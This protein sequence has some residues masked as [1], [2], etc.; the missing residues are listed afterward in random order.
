MRTSAS[1]HTIS[2]GSLPCRFRNK[3]FLRPQRQSPNAKT[4]SSAAMKQSPQIQ[5]RARLPRRPNTLD[6]ELRRTPQRDERDRERERPTPKH[7]KR[8][9]RDIRP[10]RLKTT[11][12]YQPR[13]DAGATVPPLR[14]MRTHDPLSRL[15]QPTNGINTNSPSLGKR[16]RQ[17]TQTDDR[18]TKQQAIDAHLKSTINRIEDL[19]MLSTWQVN[20]L[21]RRRTSPAD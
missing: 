12:E 21:I 16:R 6:A 18:L 15:S 14:R 19:R 4:E 17:N 7:P 5:S 1:Q 13:L 3:S 9:Q 8:A 10:N 11:V 2:S 20:A